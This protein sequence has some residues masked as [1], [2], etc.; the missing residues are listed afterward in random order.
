MAKQSPNT[1]P[2]LQ[3]PYLLDPERPALT[4][5]ISGPNIVSVLSQLVHH[6]FLG[7]GQFDVTQVQRSRFVAT[8]QLVAAENHGQAEQ[9]QWLTD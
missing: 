8:A 1:S 6:G 7:G 4:D 9:N 3:P 5:A 2:A